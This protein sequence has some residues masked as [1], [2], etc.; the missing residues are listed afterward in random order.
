MWT[1]AMHIENQ[2]EAAEGGKVSKAKALTLAPLAVAAVYVGLW[3][4][5][6]AAGI[7]GLRATLE[8]LGAL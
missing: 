6:I 5:I 4:A 1:Q 8:L 3:L 7:A 2:T